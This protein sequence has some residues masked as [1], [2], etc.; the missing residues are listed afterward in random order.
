MDT[1]YQVFSEAFVDYEMQLGPLELARMLQRRGFDPGLSFGAFDRGSLVAFT[2]N[3]IGRD[4]GI[5][6]AYDTGTGTIKTYR[7][8]GLAKQIFT[9]SIPYLKKA[10]IE[11]YLLEVLQHNDKAVHLYQKLGFAILR[12]FYYYVQKI[13]SL[14]FNLRSWN[15]IYH[16]QP[17]DFALL[18]KADFSDF[19][20]SWQNSRSSI[21]RGAKALKAV[22]IYLHGAIIAYCVFEPATGDIPSLAVSQAHRRSGLATRLLHYALNNSHSEVVKVINIPPEAEGVVAF[23]ASVGMTPSGKQFEMVKEL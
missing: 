20:S 14:R 15:S 7:G 9:H 1:L 10:G 16:M 4:Q 22:A 5:P 18:S 21:L 19:A 8:Q 23:L 17:V 2:F 6:T 11:R 12:E 13:E 3:G